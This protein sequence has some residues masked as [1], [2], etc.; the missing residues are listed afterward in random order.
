[1]TAKFHPATIAS[2]KQIPSAGLLKSRERKLI[3]SFVKKRTL[4]DDLSQDFIHALKEVLSGLVK[5][6][7]KIE[8][9]R[10]ALITG[11]SPVTPKEMKKR[12]EEFISELTR[13]KEPGKVRIVIE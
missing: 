13:G 7:V 1:M 9:L 3:D 2:K 6:S 12:F 11:G 8:D 5:V 10:T 4:P